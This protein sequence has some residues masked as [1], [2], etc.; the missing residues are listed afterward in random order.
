MKFHLTGIMQVNQN[1]ALDSEL[2]PLLY[3]YPHPGAK[4]MLLYAHGVNSKAGFLRAG[5]GYSFPV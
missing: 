3:L 4:V 1:D 5:V 2:K